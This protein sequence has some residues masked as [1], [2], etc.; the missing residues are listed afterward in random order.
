VAGTVIVGVAGFGATILTARRTAA[1]GRENR[2]WRQSAR[3][4]IDAIAA[5][6][7]RH[8]ARE[9]E[10]R[11]S[12][13]MDD[14]RRENA[15]AWLDNHEPPVPYD[16]EARLLA[17]GSAEV[18]KAVK[19]ITTAHR[20]ASRAFLTQQANAEDK[21]KT[22]DKADNDLFELIR[23]ELQGA[24]QPL[25][26]EFYKWESYPRMPVRPSPPRQP[27]DGGPAASPG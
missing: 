13:N 4:Y 17:S 12:D 16:V 7:Y 18:N 20:E 23:R 27:G 19:G 22:A 15:R 26:A 8:L 10:M 3:A 24:D 11:G 1:S 14:Q 2:V 9:F 25:G 5:T 21:R 6:S